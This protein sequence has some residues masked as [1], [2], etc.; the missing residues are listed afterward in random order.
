M[1][2]KWAALAALLALGC[3]DSREFPRDPL[4]PSADP[5]ARE[6]ARWPMPNPASEALPNPQRYTLDDE[7]IT[8]DVTGL[9][10]QRDAEQGGRGIA[11][12]EASTLC[13]AHGELWR[14]P[15]AIEL[16]SLI[17]FTE[18]SPTIAPEV[19]SPLQYFWSSSLLAGDPSRA[20]TVYFGDGHSSDGT[21]AARDSVRCVRDV[22][23]GPPSF[24]YEQADAAVRDTLTG[25]VWQQ[26]Y[27]GENLDFAAAEGHC[28]ALGARVPSMKELQTLVDR[29]QVR[30]SIDGEFFPDTASEA[31]WTSSRVAGNPELA[32]SVSF[33]LGRSDQ[34]AIGSEFYVRCVR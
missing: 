9:V 29:M 25:L 10:W 16:V 26:P 21:I 8:D 33:E 17:D 12:E 15:T 24:R 19:G 4:D 6:W 2:V 34:T 27:A 22:R 20:W 5:A 14:L 11:F 7:R 31:F 1:A 30:P 32:W 28:A 3:S 23:S 18:P 13:E